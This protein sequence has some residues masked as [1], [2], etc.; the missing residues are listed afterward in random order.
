VRAI[1]PGTRARTPEDH[2]LA[3][4]IGEIAEFSERHVAVARAH[5]A[6]LRAYRPRPYAGALSVVRARVQLLLSDHDPLLG[7]GGLA[8]GCV[9][10]HHVPG[11][12]EEM[13]T[14][15]H[16]RSLA[17]VIQQLLARAAS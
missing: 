6:A 12:H 14:P 9:T 1:V 3:Q 11:R 13:F 7:W 2:L 15:P 4:I 10:V 16:V 5:R 8:G 17:R